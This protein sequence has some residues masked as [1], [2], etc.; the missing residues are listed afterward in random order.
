MSMSLGISDIAVYLPASAIEVSEIIEKRIARDPQLEER[1][2]KAAKFTGQQVIRFPQ[3]WEDSATMAA[4]ASLRVL[5]RQNAIETNGFRYLTVGTETTVDHS[6]PLSAYVQG[7]LKGV[8][9][10][11]GTSIST[12]QIQHAC[13]GGMLSLLQVSSL[14]MAADNPSDRGIV[15]CSDIARYAQETSAEITQGAGAAALLVEHSPKLLELDIA[16]IGQFSHDVDDFFRPLGQDVA[17]VRG[18]YS[19]Q[20]Y[21]TAFIKA[22]KDYCQRLDKDP[23]EIIAGTD[24]FALHTPFRSMPLLAMEDLLSKLGGIE[25]SKCHSHLDERFFFDGIDAVAKVGNLYNASLFFVLAH[26]LKA[27]YAK[28][29]EAIVG[30]KLVLGAYGSGATML[31]LGARISAAAPAV[32][33]NWH[34]LDAGSY[35]MQS[36]DEYQDWISK[37]GVYRDSHHAAPDVDSRLFFL[38]SVRKDG[39]RIYDC[40]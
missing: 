22:F 38:K 8:G 29:G 14:L 9:L 40:A 30:K 12:S 5:G 35:S 36:F 28:C 39:Y 16:N 31:V 20:C 25:K 7:M 6:K 19:V 10:D 23:Q 3:P 11:T 27:A 17:Q 18:A 4:Q 37:K 1:L 33:K 26:M 2:R 32:I 21:R 13:A 15:I 24:F 34:M